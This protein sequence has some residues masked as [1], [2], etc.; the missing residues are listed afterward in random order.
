MATPRRLGAF[1]AG[2]GIEP[3]PE[4]THVCAECG[5]AHTNRQNFKRSDDGEGYT[6]STGHYNDKEGNLKRQRN[7]YAKKV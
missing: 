4:P 1:D 6:C 3:E 2:R 7:A 5:Y